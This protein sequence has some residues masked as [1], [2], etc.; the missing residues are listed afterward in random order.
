MQLDDLEIGHRYEITFRQYVR[1]QYGTGEVDITWR[2]KFLGWQNYHLAFR[3]AGKNRIVL[4]SSV[5]RL[6]SA[7]RVR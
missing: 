2:G 3:V 7:R 4:A 5:I 6:V 1:T